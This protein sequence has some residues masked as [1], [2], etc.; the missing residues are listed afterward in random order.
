MRVAVVAAAWGVGVACVT[1]YVAAVIVDAAWD[2]PPC[3]PGDDL[4]G[5]A[6]LALFVTVA[7]PA[8]TATYAL[9]AVYSVFNRTNKGERLAPIGIVL[10]VPTVACVL[11]ALALALA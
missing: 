9:T 11:A 3:N 6:G 8:G 7:V 2:A 10:G 1:A 5:P 4:C